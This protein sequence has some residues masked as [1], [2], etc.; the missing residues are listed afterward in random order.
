MAGV[1]VLRAL[2]QVKAVHR[3]P[4]EVVAW[5]NEEGFAP[6]TTGSSTFVGERSLE[7][8]RAIVGTDGVTF[9]KAVDVCIKR[10][11]EVGVGTCQL[12]NPIHAFIELHIEQ[13]P[14]LEM[15]A[16]DVGVV[17][18]IQG[19]SWFRFTVRGMANHAG[20]TPRAAR[21]DAFEGAAALASA[22][23]S[24]ATDKEDVTRF[25]IGRFNV[26]P[27]SINTIPDTAT[28]TVDLRHPDVNVLDTLEKNFRALARKQWA[29]CAVQVERLSRIDPVTFPTSVTDVISKSA[30]DLGLDAPRLVSGA[31]HDS[32]FLS[33]HCPTG[34][35]F[36][37]WAGGL[38]HHPAESITADHA[39]AGARVLAV[40]LLKLAN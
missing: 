3:H 24:L 2:Q 16:A 34:M 33:H 22:L 9:G 4:I 14:V 12:G 38:S 30:V 10:L 39:L 40:T 29:G 20:T 26:S 7:E 31:F 11:E 8:T 18:G 5:T 6:G 35:I 37:P 19:V 25:T 36:I 1:A 32:M 23:R 27:D 17:T 28:F 15:A 13:G 21:K